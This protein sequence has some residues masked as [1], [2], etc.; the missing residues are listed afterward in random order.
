MK[1]DERFEIYKNNKIQALKE[2][3]QT[4]ER[5]IRNYGIDITENQ[6]LIDLEKQIVRGLEEQ[7]YPNPITPQDLGLIGDALYC[8]NEELNNCDNPE[9]LELF[10][11][12]QD[13]L[14]ILEDKLLL[15]AKMN[16]ERE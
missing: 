8:Y 11:S 4:K 12:I 15:I 16:K 13:E 9:D 6:A 7:N 1:I 3:I 10:K 5:K 14:T 2:S